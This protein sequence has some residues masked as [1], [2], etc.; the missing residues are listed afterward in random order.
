MSQPLAVTVDVEGGADPDRY[1]SVDALAGFLADRDLRATLFATPDVVDYR[2]D[3]VADWLDA[4]HEVGLHLHPARLDGD[5]DR[6]SDYSVAAI[7]TLLGRGLETVTDRLGY[8]PGSF[9]AGRWEYSRSLLV[10]LERQGIERDASL[11][12][13]VHTEPYTEAGVAEF[14]LSVYAHPLI[15]LALAPW[16][17]DAIGLNADAFLTSWPRR[18]GFYALTR[19]ILRADRPYVMIAF[20]DY[21]ILA[22]P[23]GSTIAR[24]VDWLL[25]RTEPTTMAELAQPDPE[26]VRP[27]ERDTHNV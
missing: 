13:A 8:R 1:R 22:D 19:R 25:D 21:D 6:L 14:P 2:A 10:A 9:R 26:S 18:K 16:S 20:H 17:I 15:R 11:R 27:V 4:G 7:E 3:A 12:P 24:Y 23:L 5:S